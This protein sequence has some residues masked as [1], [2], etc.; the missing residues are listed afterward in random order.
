M[1]ENT[2]EDLYKIFRH[3]INDIYKNNRNV[4]N[5]NAI[6]IEDLVQEAMTAAL[7]SESTYKSSE[8]LSIQGWMIMQGLFH[9]SD[10]V[11]RHTGTINNPSTRNGSETEFLKAV[12][13]KSFE[14]ILGHTDNIQLVAKEEFIEFIHNKIN[15]VLEY[16]D[17]VFVL[18]N[19]GLVGDTPINLRTLE[20]M[21]G[22]PKTTVARRIER[23]VIKLR[24]D[25]EVQ[26]YEGQL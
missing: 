23:S 7:A 21:F 11:A 14:R 1:K 8:S 9:V 25:P 12:Y 24:D 10:Y 4:L 13:P 3:K 15:E 20:M 5:D 22:I 2:I 19:Y 6:D 16:P 18:Y 17:N 26:K